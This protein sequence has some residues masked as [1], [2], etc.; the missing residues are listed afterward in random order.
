VKVKSELLSSD[1]KLARGLDLLA[2]QVDY[3]RTTGRMDVPVPGQ[4]LYQ[5]HRPSADTGEGPTMGS[6]R[7]ATAFGW[8][9]SLVY[10]QTGQAATMTG[11]V[12]VAHQP[13]SG[14]GQ[15]FDLRGQTL[16][17]FFE[18]DS[19]AAAKSKQRTTQPGAGGAAAPAAPATQPLVDSSKF[20]LKRVTVEDDVH[21]TSPRLN[22]DA[23]TMSYDPIQQVL[24]AAGD[25]TNPILVFDNPS[26]S[27]TTASELEWNTKTDQFKVK[28]LTGKMRK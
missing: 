17:A 7:G 27:T 16:R 26:G 18:P 6:G 3:D 25:E 19:D 1:G 2:E 15:K 9:K 8:S 22:F 21:V 4:M 28:K 11:N 24:T 5:D 13:D 10:D 14:S 20:R 12:Q 23:H